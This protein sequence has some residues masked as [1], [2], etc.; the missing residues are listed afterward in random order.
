MGNTLTLKAHHQETEELGLEAH[1]G[2]SPESAAS[3][4]KGKKDGAGQ[5]DRGQGCSGMG[6]HAQG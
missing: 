4:P 5:V 1:F 3:A 6:A 2:G